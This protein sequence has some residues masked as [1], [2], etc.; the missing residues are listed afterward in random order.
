M[1]GWATTIGRAPSQ[2]MTRLRP[3]VVASL[4]ARLRQRPSFPVLVGFS[5]LVWLSLV[6]LVAP[7][8]PDEAVYKIVASGIVHGRWPYRDLFDH[9]PP[10]IYVWYLPSAFGA[11]IRFE[12]VVAAAMLALSLWLLWKIA[13][14]MLPEREARAATLAYAALL[15]SPVMAIGA[16]TE[17]FMIAPLLASVLVASPV[18]AGVLLGVAVMTKPVAIA[19]LPLLLLLRRRE[20]RAWLLPPAALAAVLAISAPFLPI[21]RSYLEAN[22]SFNLLYGGSVTPLARLVGLVTLNPLVIIAALPVWIASAVAA[23]SRRDPR[24]LLWA[25]FGLAAVK[26]TGRDY[27][28]YYVPM[29]PPVALLAGQALPALLQPGRLRRVVAAAATASLV[30]AVVALVIGWR[31]GEQYEP[32]RAVIGN[33]STELYVLGDDA[34]VYAYA[35]RQ[36]VR[37]FFYG[38]PLSLNSTWS[39]STRDALLRCP[40]QTLVVPSDPS[41]PFPIP[42][43]SQLTSL[44]RERQTLPAAVVLSQPTTTCAPPGPEANG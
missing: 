44:Y 1:S 42:W 25:A 21:W 41:T 33:K 10:L 30:A 24:L 20:R 22:V 26:A 40:P 37:R 9:K 32:L 43:T 12:R 11:S 39:D 15:A 27:G 7:Y 34:R 36:P 14:R 29:L 28:Y 5:L 19:Y 4:L 2:A 23:V 38:V 18:F 8:D 35:G 16:N 6:G 31:I 3:P 13:A 17:A